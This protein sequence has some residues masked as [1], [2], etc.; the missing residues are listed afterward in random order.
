MH[1]DSLYT[2]NLCYKELLLLPR[3][4]FSGSGR[5]GGTLQTYPGKKARMVVG[6]AIV[7]VISV[8]AIVLILQT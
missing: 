8:A 3:S 6:F 1:E 7:A 4:T 5:V 2:K